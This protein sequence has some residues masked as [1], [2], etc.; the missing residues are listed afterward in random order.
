MAVVLTMIGV[1][2]IGTALQDL[3]HTL[4]HPAAEGDISDWIAHIIWKVFRR[5]K[6]RSLTLAGPLAFLAIIAYWAVSVL[7]GFALI[8]LPHLPK[9]Y[10]FDTGISTTNYSSFAGALTVS[11]GSLITLSTGSY[12]KPVWLEFLMGVESVFGFALLTA[13]VSWILSIYPVIEHRRTLG[14]QATLLHFSDSS[15]SHPLESLDD[16]DLAH[17]LLGFAAQMTTHLNELTQFPVTYYVYEEDRETALAG[18]LPY[19]ADIAKQNATRNGAAG[20]AAIML[21]GAIDDYLK[22]LARFFLNVDS[23]NREEILKAF[24]RDQ[25]RDMVRSP[26]RLDKA[27]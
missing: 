13:S 16:T 12:A 9:A 2:M 6:L 3:F 19:L 8:Y 10:T 7:I 23:T 1:A 14:H 17:I 22:I 24:A 27:A 26:Q 5:I 15:G 25:M 20:A 21:G 4:F 18:I 11:I